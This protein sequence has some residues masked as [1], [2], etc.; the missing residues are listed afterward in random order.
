MGS[1]RRSRKPLQFDQFDQSITLGKHRLEQSAQLR[2]VLIDRQTVIR[3]TPIEFRLFSYFLER[4][5]TLVSS[6]ELARQV[7]Q[8]KNHQDA[9]IQVDVGRHINALRFKLRHSGLFIKR[10]IGCGWLLT[11]EVEQND[12]E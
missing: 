4:P 8:T 7:L 6:P 3:F 10:V 12:L 2:L 1:P 9:Q 11:D 5:R